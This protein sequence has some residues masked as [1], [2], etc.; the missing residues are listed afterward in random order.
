V[1]ALIGLWRLAAPPLRPLLLAS[2]LALLEAGSA[3]A[4]PWLGGQ[5][6]GDVLAAA[7]Q[8]FH[9]TLGLLLAALLLQQALGFTRGYLLGNTATK[10]TAA[11]RQ[12]LYDH[13]QALPLSYHQQ[14][15]PGQTLSMFSRDTAIL[16][17]FFSG[18][19][20][21]L[22]PQLITL[23][24][25]WVMMAYLD[26]TLALLIGLAV[27]AYVIGLRW[28]TRRLRPVSAHLTELHAAHLAAVEENLRLLPTLKAF[29]R[30]A[31]ESTRLTEQNAHI[32]RQEQRYL[33]A[34]GAIAPITQTAG[35]VMLALVLWLSAERLL[36]QELTTAAAISLLLY[37][38][39]L[40]RP[41]GQLAT[42]AGSSHAALG[43]AERIE[44]TLHVTA[45][46]LCGG[47]TDAPAHPGNIRFED[48]TFGYPGR[49]Q[50]FE[51]FSLD[52]QAGQTLAITGANGAGKS[53]LIHLLL[54]FVE[55]VGGRILLDGMDSRE[56]NLTT[57]RRLV[58]LVPQQVA[59]LDGTVRDNIRYGDE[60]ADERA[61][62]AAAQQALAW[63]FIVA[64]PDG[65]DTR[66]GPDGVQLSG[67]QR[68]RIALARALLRQCPILVFDEATSMFDPDGEQRFVDMAHRELGET[69]VILITHR[70]GTL[71]LADVVI[72]LTGSAAPTRTD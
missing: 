13:V 5:F 38:L 41:A 22:A 40:F 55:P 35:A 46:D 61:V 25:A 17:G 50:L 68:Q 6:A 65:M 4:M 9:L 70:P 33:R 26:P 7:S 42:A 11:L 60:D 58:G 64:L 28:L 39:L 16:G 71:A 72:E 44:E 47:L 10:T 15:S 66:L 12:R 29:G 43:A 3:L 27:P 63:D 51:H 62:I 2:L 30:E 34:M 1:N 23:I 8:P 32:V 21:S 24:G 20:P 69:T 56:L 37:G 48:I 67:G 49:T 36:E 52:I 59:L 54:R 31:Q 53:T 57:L 18:I 14:R 19:L 45:E